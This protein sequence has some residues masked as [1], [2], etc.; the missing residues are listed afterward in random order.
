MP[1]SC[2]A[3]I[4]PPDAPEGGETIDTAHVSVR[5]R[6][7]RIATI[8]QRVSGARFR[9]ERPRSGQRK[10]AL[11]R[12]AEGLKP[13]E[14]NIAADGRDIL[15]KRSSGGICRTTREREAFRD[16]R[17][18]VE[19]LLRSSP[20]PLHNFSAGPPLDFRRAATHARRAMIARDKPERSRI[21]NLSSGG[22]KRREMG[23][24]RYRA[25]AI[26]T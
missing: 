5:A 13:R 1:S 12:R 23:S 3:G 2:L 7:S 18:R 20:H 10:S 19:C 14:S 22:E 6:V 4:H 11:D 24:C 8:Q 26:H 16:V 17:R 15:Y 21:V 9:T 25:R